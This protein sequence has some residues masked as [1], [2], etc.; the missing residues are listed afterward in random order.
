VLA[1]TAGERAISPRGATSPVEVG[2]RATSSVRAGTD[3]VEGVPSCAMTWRPLL[4]GEHAERARDVVRDIADGLAAYERPTWS[5]ALFWHY[6]TATLDDDATAARAERAFER[7]AADFERGIPGVA[8]FGGLTGAAWVAAHAVDGFEEALAAVDDR[9][10]ELLASP[11]PWQ[12]PYDLIGGL[13]GLGVY[14]LERGDAPAAG[15][16]RELVCARLAELAERR[17]DVAT[18][19][20]PP[21][22]LPPHQLEL[23]PKGYYNL[24]M[25]H[26]VPGIIAVLARIAARSDAPPIAATLRDEAVRWVLACDLADGFPT[27][28]DIAGA[29]PMPTRSA[30]CYGD[31]GVVLALWSAALLAGRG[32]EVYAPLIDRWI[33]RD[34]ERARVQDAGLCHGAIGLAHACNRLFQ[35]SGI[36]RYRD[37]AR[38]WIDRGLALRRP[39]EGIG[40][41]RFVGPPDASGN[42]WIDSADFLDGAAG[43]GLGLA[44]AIT[45]VSPDWDRLLL[46]DLPT[47]EP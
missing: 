9:I 47:I 5:L 21:R 16:G 2:V 31:P 11:E 36:A 15:R 46:C 44:A 22:H 38:V 43:V 24:G 3:S 18:W 32:T 25:A 30:W 4:D 40:G 20:T 42:W 12:A 8:L 19:V 34:D 6:A 10:V 27:C 29:P 23:H 26:G 45:P 37:A 13:V 33:D 17:D 7:L 41:F 39:G 35:A 1:R 14:L 28:I